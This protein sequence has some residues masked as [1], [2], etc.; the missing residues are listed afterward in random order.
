MKQGAV[1]SAILYCIYVN[2]LYQLLRKRRYGCWVYG[3]Y[4][5]IL[6]YSDDILLLAPSINA[7][8]EM[9]GLEMVNTCESYAND[10]NLR[11]N[12]HENPSK[13]KTKCMSFIKRNRVLKPIKLCDNDL[14]WVNEIKHLG[15]MITN[16]RDIMAQDILQ[17]RAAYT[18]QN[19]ELLQE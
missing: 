18:N 8:N 16:D 13:S 4:A 11:F 5:G 15:N 2:D 10:H 12:T 7:L 1:L 9:A 19:H 14:P 3:E 6:G 17:K